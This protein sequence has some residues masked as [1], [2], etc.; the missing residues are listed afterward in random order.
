MM[1]SDL[2][3]K[4]VGPEKKLWGSEKNPHPIVLVLHIAIL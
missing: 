1:G 2:P 4:L 3:S